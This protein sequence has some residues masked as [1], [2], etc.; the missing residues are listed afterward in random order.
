M[1]M[2]RI[3]I[4]SIV[5]IFVIDDDDDD[6]HHHHNEGGKRVTNADEIK[7]IS[8]FTFTGVLGDE[9]KGVWAKYSDVTDINATDV[10]GKVM[11]TADDFGLVKLFRFPSFKKGVIRHEV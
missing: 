6:H 8:W 11:V 10:H 3:F 7:S 4:S 5:V 9:V 2:W 1:R